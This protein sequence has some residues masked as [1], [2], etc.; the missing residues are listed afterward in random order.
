M[1]EIP[2]LRRMKHSQCSYVDCL[3]L[4]TAGTLAH[5]EQPLQFPTAKVVKSHGS[6]FRVLV[7]SASKDHEADVLEGWRQHQTS[8]SQG[9]WPCEI[10]HFKFQEVC[11]GADVLTL[12]DLLDHVREG[13]F[14]CVF[15]SPPDDPAGQQPMRTRSQLLGLDGLGPKATRI[16]SSTNQHAELTAR[17]AQQALL[18]TAHRV[19]TVLIIP[20]DLGGHTDNR[21]TLALVDD[22]ISI[23]GRPG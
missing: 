20:E 9:N 22:G 21:S 6:P 3:C 18:C 2:R 7:L 16:V 4:E 5:P 8:L 17:F 14:S 1:R 19:A 15:L 23:P 10:I 12:L 13:Y 11:T